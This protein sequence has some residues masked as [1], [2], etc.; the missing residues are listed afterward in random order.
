MLILHT[1]SYTHL[2]EAKFNWEK[3][4]WALDLMLLEIDKKEYENKERVF[5]LDEGIPSEVFQKFNFKEIKDEQKSNQVVGIRIV[6]MLVFI[7]GKYISGLFLSLIH[8]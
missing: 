3:V 5:Y 8:I 4:A 2:V 7:A 1:V 6:D